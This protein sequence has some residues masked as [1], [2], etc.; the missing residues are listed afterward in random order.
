VR[1]DRIVDVSDTA[2][3]DSDAY[4][5]GR[6]RLGDRERG[7]DNVAVTPSSGLRG[8]TQR[9]RRCLVLAA[10]VHDVAGSRA[11]KIADLIVAVSAGLRGGGVARGVALEAQS[12]LDELARDGA[13][14]VGLIREALRLAMAMRSQLKA[15]RHSGA[16]TPDFLQEEKVLSSES[17]DPSSI[18]H[19]LTDVERD[20]FL[21]VRVNGRSRVEVGQEL[22]PP[23][24]GQRVGQIAAEAFL[25]VQDYV[26]R[27]EGNPP[28]AG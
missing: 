6:D 17:Q 13:S 5:S 12:T 26:K 25:K 9:E 14:W 8:L 3:I 23:L 2:L 19:V 7:N 1:E 16:R 22:S 10:N 28:D 20:V 4:E 24:T 11:H 21:A 27:R 15:R 18:G